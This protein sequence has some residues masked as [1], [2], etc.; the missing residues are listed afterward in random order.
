MILKLHLPSLKEVGTMVGP[1]KPVHAASLGTI[2]ATHAII[3]ASR[4]LHSVWKSSRPASF[5]FYDFGRTLFDAAV[6]CAHMVIQQPGSIL[7][8]EAMK[9]VTVALDVMKSLGASTVASVEGA[10]GKS[11]RNSEAIK[12]VEM[13]KRKAEQARMNGSGSEE[14][15]SS[16][17]KRKRADG[18]HWDDSSP[19]L[20]PGFQLPFVGVSVSS[21]ANEKLR[22]TIPLPKPAAIA[23][24][25]PKDDSQQ[26]AKSDNTTTKHKEKQD[27]EQEQ[28]REKEKRD[29]SKYP[30]VGIRA[31]TLTNQG[32]PSK[33]QRIGSVS[34]PPTPV[35]PSSMIVPSRTVT[36]LPAQ[37]PAATH[38]QPQQ[39]TVNAPPP[40]PPVG[41][42]AYAPPQQQQQQQQQ[43]HLHTPPSQNMDPSPRQ[44]Q[45][46][47]QQDHYVSQRDAGRYSQSQV[48][49]NTTTP[50]QTT[51]GYVEQPSSTSSF[52][53][54][55]DFSTS[56]NQPPQPSHQ[57]YYTSYAPA[58]PPQAAYEVPNMGHHSHDITMTDYSMQHTP[59][60]SVPSTPLEPSYMMNPKA[61]ATAYSSRIAPKTEPSI[62]HHYQ[63][64]T[65]G[66]PQQV[67]MTGNHIQGWTQAN[68][69]IWPEYKFYNG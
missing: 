13:M 34:P 61:Q 1:N 43:Q 32:R 3:H 12:I 64:P 49:S 29:R 19:T 5:D 39:N 60:E 41:M 23:P 30:S 25:P 11:T 65:G 45:Q 26:K 9:G 37:Q 47:M 46:H 56:Y 52:A 40:E 15:Q 2:N 58:A 69:S 28:P 16:N 10:D 54:S 57:E 55:P 24:A 20:D 51:P 48:Y 66:Q 68:P 62:T 38:N 14:G 22:P 67:T 50:P 63:Q 21:A 53:S 7:S 35:Q 17:G 36:V 6:V 59:V 42:Y 27:K 33:T 18:S 31:R 8:A 44:Q 4:L